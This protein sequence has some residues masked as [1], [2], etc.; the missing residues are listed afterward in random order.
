LASTQHFVHLKILS[1]EKLYN[2]N[3]MFLIFL[4]DKNENL[5]EEIDKKDKALD[6]NCKCM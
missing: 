2:T 1:I 5:E 3:N 4:T 6:K